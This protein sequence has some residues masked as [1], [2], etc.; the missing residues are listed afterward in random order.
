MGGGFC[1]TNPNTHPTPINMLNNKILI[2]L[3]SEF[4]SDNKIV[5]KN[6]DKQ[7][8]HFVNYSIISKYH[9]E[10]FNDIGNLM[11]INVDSGSTFGIDGIGIIIN[12]NLALSIEDV[13][14]YAQSKHLEVS[15]I[16]T[17][18]KTSESYNSGDILK[19]ISAVKSFLTAPINILSEDLQPAKQILDELY[20]SSNAK[21]LSSASPNAHL[22]YI[23]G[24]PEL[25]DDAIKAIVKQEVDS[26]KELIGDVKDFNMRVAGANFAIDSYNEIENRFEVEVSF[27]D[28]V[29]LDIIPNVKQSYIGFM[30]VK[31]FFKLI[32]DGDGDIRHNIFYENVRDFQGE[33]NSVN[34]EI[35]ATVASESE[36]NLFPL[37]NNG[38]SI[39]S[40]QLKPLGS[41]RYL[42]SGFQIING[43]QT[44]NV[45]FKHRDALINSD[46]CIPVKVV[47]V[48]NQDLVAKIIRANNRQTPVPDEAFLALSEFQKKLQDF[49][50]HFSKEIGEPLFY[51]RRNKEFQFSDLQIERHRIIT[52]HHQVRSLTAIA[53][54]DP[55][56]VYSNNPNNIIFRTKRDIL[57]K[58]DDNYY[59]YFMSCYLLFKYSLMESDGLI[60]GNHYL[61]Y[62]YTF[63]YRVLLTKHPKMAALNSRECEAESK[64]VIDSLKTM[65][66]P[67]LM[68]NA[69][70]I[71][72]EA[73]VAYKG[74]NTSNN[75]KNLIARSAF[76]DFLIPHLIPT[77][78]GSDPQRNPYRV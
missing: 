75:I 45:L 14:N 4:I 40:S 71:V 47:H 57:F 37:L 38:V 22:Y 34:Q 35:D 44:S 61:R 8:E 62:Y 42:F 10:A 66:A 65:G 21:Y 30:R 7:Y 28:C 16:F 55:H 18:I 77:R 41:N 59:P 51:E 2:G 63:A 73:L 3:C 74:K 9:P 32:T 1:W 56:V 15:L 64:L 70:K 31:E 69:I 26:L 60:Q 67:A 25:K 11:V 5:E 43:C 12:G 68:N 23:T 50:R 58:S 52:L 17:Q 76:K 48:S 53:L 33:Q 29:S 54:G 46:I 72:D 78:A 24:G 13:K 27:R 20:K 19:F 6:Q 36:R 49:Y 39:V